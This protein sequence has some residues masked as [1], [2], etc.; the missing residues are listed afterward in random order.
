MDFSKNCVFKSK[1]KKKGKK[2][3]Y[4]GILATSK[5]LSLGDPYGDLLLYVEFKPRPVF[6]WLYKY[7]FY[8]IQ[9]VMLFY[10][11]ISDVKNSIQILCRLQ[12][13]VEYLLVI[14]LGE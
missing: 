1:I 8:K 5:H 9:C 10:N 3:E 7:N 12:A 2:P 11:N 14:Y 4:Y 6:R 13:T